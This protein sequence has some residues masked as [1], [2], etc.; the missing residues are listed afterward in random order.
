MSTKRKK[1]NIKSGVDI[2]KFRYLD[3]VKRF[4]AEMKSEVDDI[5]QIV[6]QQQMALASLLKPKASVV[7]AISFD[8][9]PTDRTKDLKEQ[10]KLKTKIDPTLTKVVVPNLSKLK[11][12]YALAE[13]LYEKHRTLEAVETQLAMQFPDRRGEAYT[14]TVT[15]M[16]ALKAKV[17]DQLKSV[18]GF[19][20]DVAQKHVPKSFEAYMA[21]IVSLVDE[22]VICRSN[23]TFLYVSIT[24]DGNLVFTYYMMLEDAANDE[25]EITPALYVSVQWVVGESVHVDLNTEYEVPNKLLGAGEEVATVG[26]ASKAINDLLMVENFSSAL[27]VVPLALQLKVDPSKISTEMFQYRDFIASVRVDENI[28]G[29]VLRKEA[30]NPEL[31]KQIGY[32]IYMELKQV[33]KSKDAKLTLKMAKAPSGADVLNFTIRQ[34]AQSG[35]LST[36]DF[37]FLKDKF[38]LSE[39]QLKRI[40][41]I[42]NRGK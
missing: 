32:Q 16:A 25:G 9:T 12:Q 42:I 21:A 18:L 13:D 11:S 38:G 24:E 35:S 6:K 30:D 5:T 34:V 23:K 7:A 15:A 33:L 41:V 27:G 19:L 40:A 26:E 37:E 1:T 17:A 14:S 29:F 2:P 39:Q 4:L 31:V 20:G 22:N 36:F 8:I 28:I 10:R 3:D